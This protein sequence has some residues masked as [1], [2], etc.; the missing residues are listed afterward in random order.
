MKILFINGILE[1]AKRENKVR[2]INHKPKYL[3]GI[4]RIISAPAEPAESHILSTNS[5]RRP[6]SES[7]GT[8]FNN[9]RFSRNKAPRTLK[10]HCVCAFK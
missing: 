2:T 5:R 4:D 9:T 6:V 3:P 10:R 8:T 1:R 7:R